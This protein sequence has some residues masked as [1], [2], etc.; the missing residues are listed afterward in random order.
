[1][2]PKILLL[3]L[4]AF[5]PLSGCNHSARISQVRL[6]DPN[7]GISAD[8]VVNRDGTFNDEVQQGEVT[9]ILDGNLRSL[10]DEQYEVTVNYERKTYTSATTFKSDKLKCKLTTVSGT[11]VPI[12][13]NP[14]GSSTENTGDDASLDGLTIELVSPSDH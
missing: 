13:K 1:M 14:D 3:V 10:G 9:A 4:I 8:V 2:K 11:V 5:I 6:N 12:G 7:V